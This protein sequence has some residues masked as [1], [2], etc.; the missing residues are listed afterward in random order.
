M[1]AKPLKEA[2]GGEMTIDKA[3]EILERSYQAQLQIW[4]KVHFTALK[5]GIEAL[6]REKEY[7]EILAYPEMHFLPGETPEENTTRKQE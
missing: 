5:L 7:R 1:L 6:K 2:K 3:I 4:E